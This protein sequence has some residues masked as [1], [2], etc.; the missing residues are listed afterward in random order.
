M[1]MLFSEQNCLYITM[2]NSHQQNRDRNQDRDRNRDDRSTIEAHPNRDNGEEKIPL[3]T[4]SA[5]PLR[6]LEWY[7]K[8]GRGLARSQRVRERQTERQIQR[9][10]E[11]KRERERQRDT[12]TKR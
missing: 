11:R 10:T 5:G 2:G 4:L 1:H 9:Q 8:N 12:E 3:I 7:E 6:V